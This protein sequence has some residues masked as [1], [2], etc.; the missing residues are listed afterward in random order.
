MSPKKLK[1]A[2]LTPTFQRDQFL[3]QTLSYFLQQ[4]ALDAE[5]HWFL[6]DDSPT[7][8]QHVD[9]FQ[10]HETVSYLWQSEKLSIGAK[11]N[12]LNDLARDWKSDFVCSMDDDD[13]YGPTYVREM[14]QLL[15]KQPEYK[16]S[17][18][19]VDYYYEVKKNR[20]LKI[21]AVS[22]LSSCNG[23]LCYRG[24][25]LN[26]HRYD[27]SAKFAEEQSFLRKSPV[28]QH[29]DIQKLHLALAHAKNTVTK[30]NYCYGDKYQVDL[31]LNDFPMLEQDK[32]FYLDLYKKTL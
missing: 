29:P 4:Q 19:G 2:V 8:S 23:V 16:F 14:I 3:L 6:F 12:R 17:G 22:E 28:V 9:I 27:D 25:I 15:I 18:S 11:R 26:S 20:I 1:I 5:L 13:W 30:K 31:T 21:P 24:D 7:P 32:Q 10:Q